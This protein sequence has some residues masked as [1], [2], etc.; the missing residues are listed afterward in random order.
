M[1]FLTIPETRYN[2]NLFIAAIP[3]LIADTSGE[4]VTLNG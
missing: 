1:E 4:E 3:S 2:W